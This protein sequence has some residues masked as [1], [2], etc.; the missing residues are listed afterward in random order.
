MQAK[1][2]YHPS[3][4][5]FF[6]P[7]IL[8]GT[9]V[10]WLLSNLNIIPSDNLWI[11]LRL[12]PVLIIVAGLDVLF[13][14]RLPGIGALLALLVIGGVVYILLFGVDLDI[15]GKPELQTQEFVVV[16]QNTTLANIEL[17][18]T[19]HETI[20]QPLTD[21]TSLVEAQVTHFGEVDFNVTGAEHKWIRLTHRGVLSFFPWFLPDVQDT[22][23]TWH[24]GLSPGV[25]LNLMVD[26]GTGRTEIDLS[27][28]NV[29]RFELDGGTGTS[30][31]VLGAS[32][33]GYETYFKAGTGSLDIIFP[34]Q[35]SIRV[36][37]KGSTGRIQLQMPEGAAVQIEVLRG[38]T[39]DLILPTWITQ[40][41]GKEGRDEGVYQSPGFDEAD[42]Q[43]IVMVERIRTG[44]IIVE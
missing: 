2:H 15:E 34:V 33:T 19:T 8:L 12:W 23:L 37:L 38:G 4:R 9:G 11:L 43:I 41:S 13:A 21:S 10:I 29:T 28:L 14:H 25:P 24:I 35:S 7:V 20:I 18:L 3:S 39:G 17:N 6:W 36:N 32:D 27:G 30:Q 42:Q 1:K 16:V 22:D 31:V 26:A 5:S 44:N 40:V